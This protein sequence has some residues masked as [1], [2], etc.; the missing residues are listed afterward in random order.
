M[1]R[2]IHT[3][4]P[5]VSL[6]MNSLGSIHPGIIQEAVKQLDA[7]PELW[8]EYK[9]RT[10]SNSPHR[11]ADDIWVRYNPVVNFDPK[12][13]AKFNDEHTAEWYS[14]A[15]KLPA[16]K[17]IATQVIEFLGAE[18]L[19][20]VLVTRVPPGKQIH[21]HQ[22]G[23]WHAKAHRKFLVLLR[24]NIEQSFEFENE[25]MFAEPGDC[26][27][28]Q[29]EYLHSVYNPTDQERISLIICLRGF[30]NELSSYN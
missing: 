12:N 15:D 24:G 28:F 14:C 26:F 22:D 27:E 17:E 18:K 3:L 5:V 19:G 9:W 6:H 20:A 25:Q 7:H 16:I 11:E 23:G 4:A 29:N 13:P 2:H 30:K 8:N 1:M 21:W 10:A